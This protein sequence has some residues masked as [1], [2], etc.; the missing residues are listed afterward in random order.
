MSSTAEDYEPTATVWR[1]VGRLEQKHY[2]RREIH[3]ALR[4]V[5]SAIKPEGGFTRRE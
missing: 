4:G 3:D 2:T 5:A 1:A